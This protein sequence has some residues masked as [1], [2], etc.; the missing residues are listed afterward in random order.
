MTTVLLAMVAII[1]TSTSYGRIAR[2]YP[3][4]GSAFTYVGQEIDP[5]LGYVTGWG[6]VMGLHAQAHAFFGA[7]DS[8][9]H[10][11]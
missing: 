5:R 7:V 3:S 10:V 6:M 4:A 11:P 8:K 2:V 1:F 9:H